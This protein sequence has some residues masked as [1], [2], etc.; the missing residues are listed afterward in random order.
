M[1]CTPSPT[2]L[3]TPATSQPGLKGRGGF[4]WY[5]PCTMRM[6]GKLQPTARTSMT[7]S[8]AR[9]AGSGTS[10]Y[11]SD[12]GS[13]SARASIAFIG[14]FRHRGERT[15]LPPIPPTGLGPSWSAPWPRSLPRGAERAL[16]VGLDDPVGQALDDL[17]RQLRTIADEPVQALVLEDEQLHVGARDGVGGAGR[18]A[19]EAEIAEQLAVAERAQHLVVAVEIAADLYRARVHDVR[20]AAWVG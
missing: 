10:A 18:V 7:T 14:S 19:E 11:T 15:P 5:L 17:G 9:G 2:P 8:P 20:F 12:D 3:T 16:A 6:S 4:F 13:P 1:P